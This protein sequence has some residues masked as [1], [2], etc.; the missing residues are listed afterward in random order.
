LLFREPARLH[1]HPLTGDGLYPFLEEVS[2][3]SSAG[4]SSC[5][6]IANYLDV[7]EWNMGD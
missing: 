5:S 2:G 1:V 3:L 7:E 4:A 6:M